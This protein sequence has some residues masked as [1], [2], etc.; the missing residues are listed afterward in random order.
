MDDYRPTKSEDEYFVSEL[1][2]PFARAAKQGLAVFG[3]WG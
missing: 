1:A 2:E 3:Q